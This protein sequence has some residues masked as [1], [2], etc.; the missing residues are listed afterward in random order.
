MPA[1]STHQPKYRHYKPKDLAVVRLGGRDVYLGKFNSP[2]SWEKYGRVLAEWHATGASPAPVK[3]SGPAAG[4]AHQPDPD[5]LSVSELILAFWR[6]A[7]RHYRRAD[8]TPTD[9]L[10]NYRL[11]LRLLRQ[12]YGGMPAGTFTAKDLKVVRQAMIDAALSRGVV[13]QRIGRIVHLFKWAEC[14]G[15]VP[16]NT[17]NS[18]RT[19]EGL[20]RGRSDARETAPIKPVPDAFVDAVEPHVSMQVWA[21]IRLQ[22]LTGMRPG[23]VTAMRTC[24]LDT[25]GAIWLY[26]PVRHKM[27]HL[28]R[29]RTI[30]LG[31]RAQAVLRPWLRTDLADFLFSPA[32]AMAELSARRR[33]DRK[34]PLTPSQRARTR[35][36]NPGRRP[37]DRYTTRSYYHA[38]RRACGCAGV[39]GWHPNRLRHNAATFLRKE[40]GLDVA[41]VILG[42]SSP[43]VTL[44]YAE[45]DR[46]KAKM[47]MGQVG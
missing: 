41:R 17:H 42:H 20:R 21:M 27:E 32:E 18:L 37:G 36:R 8:G 31:P 2:E 13:N 28:G 46:E 29:E 14:E 22:R 40:F 47:V 33:R 7:E 35:K 5:A 9:E 24:D 19:L 3:H 6:H 39:P 1:K 23:E 4:D 25:S 26:T 11:S 43:A 44:V 16:R 10:G 45:A 30:Y 12:L 34:T 15:L 38:I